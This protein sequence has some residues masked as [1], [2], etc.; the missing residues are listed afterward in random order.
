MDSIK[1]VTV[2]AISALLAYLG[3]VHNVMLLL[4]IMSGIDVLVGIPCSI[5]V[6]K[7]R[8][9]FKKFILAAV[10]LLIY[11]CIIALIYTVGQFQDDEAA[12]LIVVK[13]LTYVFI[14][15][16]SANTLKNL[17]KLLPNHKGI[18]FMD[19]IIGLEF[20][21]KVPQ[22]EAFLN[23]KKQEKDNG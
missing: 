20:T 18:A 3:P 1:T 14:Y 9:R 2:T 19:Y 22:L 8:F 12:T 7:E 13:T 4:F 21:K 16:Y 10:Y 23:Q 5:A 15:F 11:L 6:E 17:H